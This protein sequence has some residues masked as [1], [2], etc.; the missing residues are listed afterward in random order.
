MPKFALMIGPEQK[1]LIAR[2]ISYAKKNVIAFDTLKRLAEQVKKGDIEAIGN[3][4]HRTISLPIDCLVTYTEEEQPM[5]LCRHLSISHRGQLPAI[6]IV[7]ELMNHFG[8]KTDIYDRSPDKGDERAIYFEPTGKAISVVEL[9]EES[10]YQER[11]L[12]S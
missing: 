3:T 6:E 2:C 4:E 8:F 9:M 11:R 1:I 5:G 10:N 7:A 12:D